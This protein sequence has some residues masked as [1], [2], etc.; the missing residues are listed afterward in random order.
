MT[1]QPWSAAT[2][3]FRLE[4]TPWTTITGPSLSADRAPA[5]SPSATCCSIRLFPPSIPQD[6]VLDHLRH[7]DA[8]GRGPHL[9]DL[10]GGIRPAY[11]RHLCRADPALD[12]IR[13]RY[14]AVSAILHDGAGRAIGGVAD[15]RRRALPVF[16]GY[17]VA[18]VGDDDRRAIRDPV[19]LWLESI[20]VA[21]A[22]HHAGLDA[23]HRHRH[24][25]NAD[26][27]RRV[28]RMAAGDGNGRARDVAA[29][30]GG[31][32]HAAPVRARTGRDG[33]MRKTIANSEWRIASRTLSMLF[34]LG[35]PY[36]L[37]ATRY[38]LFAIRPR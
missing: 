8:A 2:C 24:Q 33:K 19:H 25:E 28:G 15:R 26:D 38:S 27:N 7:A 13:D 22:D 21:A 29:G 9:S 37:F 30:R 3:R 17:V 32:V 14:A 10:Q 11:A 36:S 5:A 31:G 34:D 35:F 6:R 16:Q 4:A 12:R 20:F 18:A 1:R 23:D